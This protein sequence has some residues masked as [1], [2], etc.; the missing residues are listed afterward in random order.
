MATWADWFVENAELTAP[1]R[2]YLSAA[3]VRDD[4]ELV[5]DLWAADDDL[6]RKMALLWEPSLTYL[7]SQGVDD[8]EHWRG[9][10]AWMTQTEAA[11][12]VGASP[13]KEGL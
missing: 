2:E 7:R 4:S 12:A 5:A 3:V 1:A 9:F 8:A 6:T 10:C 11:I 13:F